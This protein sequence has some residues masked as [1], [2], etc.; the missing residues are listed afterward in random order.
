VTRADDE[1]GQR[2][3]RAFY[4]TR[5]HAADDS[6]WLNPP[7]RP[8]ACIDRSCGIRVERCTPTK[9]NSIR[10]ASQSVWP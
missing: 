3:H 2:S 5:A 1:R 10:R 9:L 8:D 4:S 6:L 7:C